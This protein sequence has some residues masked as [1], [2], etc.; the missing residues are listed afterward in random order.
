M[1]WHTNSHRDN[2]R[3]VVQHTSD[4]SGDI[5]TVV[6]SDSTGPVVAGSGSVTI[7]CASGT[8]LQFSGDGFTFSA[9]DGTS[10]RAQ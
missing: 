7:T 8:T 1:S 5:T 10:K 3:P 9:G 2:S 4:V 6:I